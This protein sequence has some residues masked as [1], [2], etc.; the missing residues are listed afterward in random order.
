MLKSDDEIIEE[1][2]ELIEEEKNLV[3]AKELV[4]LSLLEE[5]DKLEEK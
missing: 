3:E 4:L 1:L 2:K 5:L